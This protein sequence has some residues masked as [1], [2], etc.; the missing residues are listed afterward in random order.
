MTE[1]TAWTDCDVKWRKWWVKGRIVKCHTNSRGW[2]RGEK[3]PLR[4]SII[5]GKKLHD[6][7]LTVKLKMKKNFFQGKMFPPVCDQRVAG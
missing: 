5:E 2:Q 3:K 6:V 1:E 7:T 4:L